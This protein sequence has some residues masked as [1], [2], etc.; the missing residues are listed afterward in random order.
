MV[1]SQDHLCLPRVEDLRP[2]CDWV[3]HG[4]DQA[5]IDRCH[6][7][8]HGQ[9]QPTTK[10]NLRSIA[11]H[12]LLQ[13]ENGLLQTEQINAHMQCA[14]EYAPATLSDARSFVSLSD[15]ADRAY[16]HVAWG[17]RLAYPHGLWVPYFR[18]Q[19]GQWLLDL[20]S[21]ERIGWHEGYRFLTIFS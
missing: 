8:R 1:P 20:S 15:E 11:L 17:T 3:Y 21:L 18:W 10:K 16:A 14:R 9:S 4:F 7:S 6:F 13:A 5:K 12:G 19:N 2:F